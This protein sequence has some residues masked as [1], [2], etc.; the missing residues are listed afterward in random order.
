LLE[1][2]PLGVEQAAQELRRE[3][4][5]VWPRNSAD[6]RIHAYR[7]ECRRVSKRLENR[8]CELVTQVDLALGAIAE[9]EPEAEGAANLHIA[10]IQHRCSSFRKLVERRNGHE[11]LGTSSAIP[12]CEQLVAMQLQPLEDECSSAGWELTAYTLGW[13]E[14]VE[15]IHL[16]LNP[17]HR[18]TKIG[19]QHEGCDNYFDA[20]R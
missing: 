10:H 1:G 4:R 19:P 8:A 14:R 13:S 15:D 7:S 2:S 16:D 12:I 6:F 17:Q 5:S 18:E 20:H 11:R 3:I 9:S